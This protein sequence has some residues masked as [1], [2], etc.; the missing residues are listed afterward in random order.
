MRRFVVLG[1][2]LL[3]GTAAWACGDKLLA[4]GRG[5][6]FQRAYAAARQANVVIYASGTE[7]GATLKAPKLQTTLKQIGHK[8]Q[9][10]QDAAGL[11]QALKAGR[12][13]VVLADVT[14]A[15][16]IARQLQSATS[17]P[18]VLPV[19][20]KP[21]K[22]DLASAQKQYSFALKAP[23]DEVQYLVAIDEVMK[24]RVKAAAKS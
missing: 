15:A 22:A 11:E 14:D 3:T 23:G 7:S 13:D 12:V 1:A 2:L 24:S 17:K 4:F 5:V 21:S 8:L 20:F 10:V 9:T 19:L 6:R 18:V 16:A